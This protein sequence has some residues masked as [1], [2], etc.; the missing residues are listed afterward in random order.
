MAAPTCMWC[1]GRRWVRYVSETKD[2][3][4]EEAFRLCHCNHGRQAARARDYREEPTWAKNTSREN[5]AGRCIGA[6]ELR[7]E[8]WCRRS[9]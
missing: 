5:P 3:D 4:L 6:I 7:V 2:G 9:R 1:R 8:L